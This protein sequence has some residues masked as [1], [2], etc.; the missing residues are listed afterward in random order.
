[1]ERITKIRVEDL[2]LIYGKNTKQA[3]DMVQAG[4]SQ[5]AIFQQTKSTVAVRN[6]NFAVYEHELLVIMGL[7]GSGKSSL[8]KCLNL[9]NIPT[10]GAIYVDE[11]NILDYNKK[12]LREYRQNKA[13]M[14]F[15]NFGLLPNRTVLSNVEFGMEVCNI[16][17]KA[18]RNKAMELINMVGLSG[19]ENSRPKELSG[20]MQQRVGLAR[21]LA[22]DPQILLMDEPFSALDPLIRRQMQYELLKLQEVLKKTIVFITHDIDEAFMLGDRIAIM[23]EGQFQQL[24]RPYEIIENPAN[25]YVMDFIKDINRLRVYTARDIALPNL[26]TE[27]SV[28]SIADDASLEQVFK[29]LA[30]AQ[31]V[32]V[33]DSAGKAIGYIDRDTAVQ[34][35]ASKPNDEDC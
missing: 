16:D 7:S 6:V 35:F 29:V 31:G 15:Q 14:V 30:T 17:K 19:W 24:G 22:N 25:E 13:S 8:I 33:V 21:A 28:V 10:S 23:K 5:Q 34:V 11:E 32:R 12:Q 18:R 4:E 9:L 2:M 20:G 3:L 1:M 26:A 27:G